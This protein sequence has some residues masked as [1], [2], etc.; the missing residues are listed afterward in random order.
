MQHWQ[1]RLSD[2]ITPWTLQQTVTATVFTIAKRTFPRFTLL[3]MLFLRGQLVASSNFPYQQFPLGISETLQDGRCG[4]RIDVRELEPG[5][6]GCEFLNKLVLPWG[7]EESAKPSQADLQEWKGQKGRNMNLPKFVNLPTK[8]FEHVPKSS[9][10]AMDTM[11]RTSEPGSK[12]KE[13]LNQV[14]GQSYQEKPK[15]WEEA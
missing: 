2:F 10:W 5:P 15:Q 12:P 13:V 11:K 14:R 3:P 6:P 8:L 7:S 1:K 9:S 4:I